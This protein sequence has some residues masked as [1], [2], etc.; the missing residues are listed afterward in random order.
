MHISDTALRYF[1]AL[2]EELHFTRAAARLHIT[3]PSLSQS[4]SRLE[5]Q[6]GRQLLRRSPQGVTL[7]DDGRSLLPLAQRA[8]A[9]HDLVLAWSAEAPQTTALNIGIVASGAGEVTSRILT[10]MVQRHPGIRLQLVR[11]GFFDAAEAIRAGRVDAAFVLAPAPESAE[12]SATPLMS[13]PR[14][15]VVRADH[16]IA[17]RASVTIAET[18]DLDFVVPSAAAG[19][20]RSWWL[21]DPRSDGSHPRVVAT[22]DDVEGLMELCAAGVGVNIATRSVATHFGRADLAYLDIVDI[23]PAEVLLVR[24]MHPRRPA[25]LDFERI[26]LEAVSGVTGTRHH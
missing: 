13:E 14:V 3:T 5:Q 20:A 24:A 2:A 18:D 1:V 22:A 8:V 9:A 16:P 6:T 4:I 15:L 7:T 11:L 19:A 10:T 17:A 25:T 21:I 12:F 23:A 26:A